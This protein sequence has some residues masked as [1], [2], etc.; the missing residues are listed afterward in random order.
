MSIIAYTLISV[1]VVSLISLVGTF[2]I[3]LNRDVLNRSVFFLVSLAVGALFGDAIIHL[4]PEA[5]EEFESP[6]FAALFI[7]IG[8][9]IF[10]VLEKFL[11]WRHS[12]GING[13]DDGHRIT[14]LGPIVLFSD[15][16]HNFLDGVIIAAAYMV[17][18]EVGIATTIAIILHEIPQEIGDFGVLIHAGYT[19]AKALLVNFL[20]ALAAVLGAGVALLIGDASQNITPAL[21][22]LA[23]GSFLYIAGSDLVPELHKTS[24][25]KKSLLQFIAIIIGFGLMFALVLLE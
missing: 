16:V 18:I 10:F 2:T 9:F 7:I 3:S 17:S 19:R 1:L 21:I 11:H 5:F 20:S 25:I 24:G 12:H 8:I 15:G 4:I 22:A 6:T 14:P 13:H 23:A